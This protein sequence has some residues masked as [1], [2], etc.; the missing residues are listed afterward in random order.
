MYALRQFDDMAVI[1]VC[2][3]LFCWMEVCSGAA[4]CM[5]VTYS[6][7]ASVIN[8]FVKHDIRSLMHAGRQQRP[9]GIEHLVALTANLAVCD[10]SYYV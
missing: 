9:S 5:C 4:T 3:S 1:V 6:G 2:S 8:E 7:I 10:G